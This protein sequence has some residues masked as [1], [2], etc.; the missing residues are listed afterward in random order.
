[1]AEDSELL[2]VAPMYLLYVPKK[3][4]GLMD[5]DERYRVGL[6]ISASSRLYVIYYNSTLVVVFTFLLK[7]ARLLPGSMGSVPP[8]ASPFPCTLQ[9]QEPLGQASSDVGQI[10]RL[11]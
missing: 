11:V 6:N 1:M 4:T 9:D 10:I 3:R 5:V 8:N 7:I 2:F